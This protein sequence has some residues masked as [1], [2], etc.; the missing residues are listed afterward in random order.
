[1]AIVY[2]ARVLEE[3]ME[4]PILDSKTEL[5][6]P[7]AASLK[8]GNGCDQLAIS[9][10]SGELWLL[11]VELNDAQRVKVGLCILD[12][13]ELKNLC[14]R[15]EAKWIKEMGSWVEEVVRAQ[16]WRMTW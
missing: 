12:R 9:A 1:V 14:C 4:G 2:V 13:V 6:F 7:E 15:R 3:E 16:G 8:V 10:A 11:K 5:A